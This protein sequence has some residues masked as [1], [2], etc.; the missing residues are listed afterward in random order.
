[1]RTY[2]FALAFAL[3]SLACDEKSASK[4]RDKSEPASD[5]DGSNKRDKKPDD[6]KSADQPDTVASTGSSASARADASVPAPPASAATPPDPLLAGYTPYST[7]AG[8]YGL[9]M[10]SGWKESEHTLKDGK[11]IQHR[12]TASKG[13]R[14]D[15]LAYWQEMGEQATP[16]ALGASRDAAAGLMEEPR[17]TPVKV[18]GAYDG[19]DVAGKPKS[20]GNDVMHLRMFIA[21]KRLYGLIDTDLSDAESKAWM[22]SFKLSDGSKAAGAASKPCDDYWVKSRKCNENAFAQIPDGAAKEQIKKGFED[23]EKQT[24]EAWKGLEGASLDNAC[25]QMI[26]ALKSNPNCKD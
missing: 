26:E 24:R 6:K 18:L 2:A 19:F 11:T 13:V 16:A 8:G 1:M 20:G 4:T 17:V 12:V 23:A 15:L 10:P 25:K 21:N 7:A 5:D 22:S 9:L 3:A 14:K